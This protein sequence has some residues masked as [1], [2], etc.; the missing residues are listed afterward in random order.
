M[1]LFQ[2]RIEISSENLVDRS[3]K[4]VIFVNPKSGNGRA[5]NMFEK[6]VLPALQHANIDFELILTQRKDTFEL[7]LTQK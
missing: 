2:T 1:S 3:K 6:S 5:V 7:I 4:L